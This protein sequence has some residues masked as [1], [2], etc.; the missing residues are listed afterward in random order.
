MTFNM[1]QASYTQI[2]M[3]VHFLPKVTPPS[4]FAG[5]GPV[6]YFLSRYAFLILFNELQV[7][8]LLPVIVSIYAGWKRVSEV[9]SYESDKDIYD[10]P[11]IFVIAK[12]PLS[13]SV[14]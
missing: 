7:K 4:Q 10:V 12:E 8:N 6:M 3:M 13:V 1:V 14:G 11:I 5:Y 2:L 9:D